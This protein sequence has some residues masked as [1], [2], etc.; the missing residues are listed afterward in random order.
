L[1]NSRTADLAR[2]GQLT[3]CIIPTPYMA[4]NAKLLHLNIGMRGCG[5][6]Q[7]VSNPIPH[8]RNGLPKPFGSLIQIFFNFFFFSRIYIFIHL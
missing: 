7:I 5:T 1:A 6:A 4:Q 8:G 2:I 3:N